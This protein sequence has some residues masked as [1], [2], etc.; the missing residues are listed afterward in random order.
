MGLSLARVG[1]LNHADHMMSA[2]KM[3]KEFLFQLLLAISQ[4][5]LYVSVPIK[6]IS[7]KRVNKLI[8][9][10]ITLCLNII[11]NFHKVSHML[12]WITL[13][14]KWLEFWQLIISRHI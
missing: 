7:F 13:T 1:E 9:H 10:Q 4:S 8:D 6:G 11:A 5:V 12:T 2:V 14:I 3:I